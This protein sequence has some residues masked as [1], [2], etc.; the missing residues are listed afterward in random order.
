MPILLTA[1]CSIVLTPSAEDTA[2][3]GFAPC[4][5][6]SAPYNRWPLQPPPDCLVAT[7]Y[8]TGHVTPDMSMTD[9]F[10]DR[11]SLWQFYGD[12]VLIE[13]TDT[14]SGHLGGRWTALDDIQSRYGDRGFQF[15]TLIVAGDVSSPPDVDDLRQWASALGVRTPVLADDER[16]GAEL[17]PNSAYPTHILIDRRM[18]FR[19]I[20]VLEENLEVALGS[21]LNE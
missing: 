17:A 14:W 6:W 13:V 5:L 10:G 20:G 19:S 8:T 21:M 7:G 9:Q 11:V 16:H 12:V 15:L 2:V 4:P 18:R 1:G 3:P